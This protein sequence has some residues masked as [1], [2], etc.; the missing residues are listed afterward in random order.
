MFCETVREVAYSLRCRGIMS[1]Y[2]CGAFFHRDRSVKMLTVDCRVTL[3]ECDYVRLPTC[4]SQFVNIVL[5]VPLIARFAGH[6]SR[7]DRRYRLAR[8]AEE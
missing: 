3:I 1:R 5:C 4:N 6:E 2:N 8:Y 7:D